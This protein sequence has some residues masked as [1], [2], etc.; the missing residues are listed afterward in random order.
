MLNWSQACSA[1][2]DRP[3]WQQQQ[4]NLGAGIFAVR[5]CHNAPFDRD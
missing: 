3:M 2:A 4:A 5:P 1:Q